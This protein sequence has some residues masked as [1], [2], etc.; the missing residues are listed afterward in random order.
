M[1]TREEGRPHRQSGAFTGAPVTLV[2][3][4][5]NLAIFAGEVIASRSLRSLVEVPAQVWLAFGANYAPLTLALGQY[6]RLVASCFVHG[7]LL[8]VALNM[9]SLRNIGPFVERTVGSARYPVLY[10]V[11]GIVG[12]VSSVA[13]GLISGHVVPSVGASGAICGILGAALVLGVR[14]EGWRSGIARQIGFWIVIIVAYGATVPGIDNA[15]H[16]GGMVSGCLIA[17]AWRRGVQYSQLATVACIAVSAAVCIGAGG[18]VVWR[19]ATDP[20]ALRGPNERSDLVVLALKHHDCAGARKALVAT[21][22][23][24]APTPELDGLR[25]EV[26]RACP[27]GTP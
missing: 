17:T 8:H 16:V 19:D 20:Y 4:M 5:A 27:P 21:E 12:S 6:D 18:A 10:V 23:V 24:S 15:A 25:A 11:T 2:I 9:W 22:A 14:L 7:S 3:V 1:Q 13:W 26:D